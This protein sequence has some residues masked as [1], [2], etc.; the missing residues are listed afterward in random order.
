[1]LFH[2]QIQFCILYCFL[3][4]YMVLENG[5][6]HTRIA[7]YVVHIY[8][9]Y[10]FMDVTLVLLSVC[11]CL[12]N[13]ETSLLSLKYLCNLVFKCELTFV[14][15]ILQN[16]AWFTSPNPFISLCL[17]PYCSTFLIHWP[18]LAPNHPEVLTL[19]MPVP[20][21]FHSHD[22]FLSHVIC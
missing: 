20:I 3:S 4:V 12:F 17:W 19:E 9:L 11:F 14:F 22:K 18:P 13:S 21:C 8:W 7:L 2:V 16:F 5:W 6:Y 1:M 10:L 15:Q